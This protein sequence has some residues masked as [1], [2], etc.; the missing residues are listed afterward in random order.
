MRLYD[1][2][3]APGCQQVRIVLAEKG[4][5]YERHIVLP[6]QEHEAWY[7]ELN[8]LARVPTLVDR[9]LILREPSVITEYLEEAYPDRPMMPVAP[10]E[11]AIARMVVSFV[12][13]YLAPPMED[14]QAALDAGASGGEELD[15]L[16]ADCSLAFEL[17]GDQLA[18]GQAFAAGERYTLADAA[19]IPYLFEL[20]AVL[21][22]EEAIETQA[23]VAA[24]RTRVAERPSTRV[25][26]QAWQ[27]WREMAA[28]I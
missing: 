13:Q 21:D 15:E 4:L 18:S 26:H 7:Q 23:P 10:G 17:L 11:R 14:L 6:G 3:C 5:S 12:E 27:E 28:Q 1:L 20:P 25:V 9:D 2:P 16:R 19:L 24:Y 22:L 8:P